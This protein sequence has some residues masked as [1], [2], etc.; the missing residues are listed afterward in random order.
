MI[1]RIT[2]YKHLF[3]D[4]NFTCFCPQFT[5]VMTEDEL[6]EILPNYDGWIIGDDPATARV[7]EAGVQG[8]LKA[9]VKWG[10]GTDNVDFDACKR[11]GIPITNIPN[12]FGEEV[13]DVGMGMLLNLTR[14]LHVINHET[15]QGNWIK[16]S[17]MS[18]S[19]KKVCLIGFGDIGRSMARKL[20][21]FNLDVYVSDPGFEKVDG[22]IICNYSDQIIVK[23]ELNRV[24]MVSLDEALE[25][26][27]FICI[28]CSLNKATH[29]IV[30]KENMLKAKK[31]VIIVNVA[32]GPVVCENDVV[33]LLECGHIKAVGFDVFETEPLPEYSKLR[34]HPQNFFGSHNGSNTVEGVDK[35]SYI[36]VAK[37]REFL[38]S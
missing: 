7:F 25:N 36:A 16:P 32:R 5:Q 21:A 18:L 35:T 11:L 6:I 38:I 26:T 34:E 27:D 9:A 28:T 17:G 24:N 30:N 29:H 20:L 33:E 37:M 22:K 4:A 31:G 10:V 23:E 12:V 14:Q 2:E 19:G 8:K 1:K 15:T 13:S 3:K